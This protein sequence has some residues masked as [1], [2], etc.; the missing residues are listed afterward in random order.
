MDKIY[1]LLET[2]EKH[3]RL[4]EPNTNTVMFG[5]LD[6][7]DLEKT[8]LFPLTHFNLTAIEYNSNTID[9]T[10]SLMALDI[11]N[12]V[13]TEDKSFLGNDN[14]QDVLN[15]QAAVINK[16]VESLRVNKGYLA[17][18][19]FVI[20]NDP[21]AEYLSEKYKNNLAGWGMDIEI[22]TPNDQISTCEIG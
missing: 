21:R 16:L 20:K 6:E 2:I 13:K 19:Q 12:E 11:V 4:N 5:K 3:F 9:F 18:K 22:S 15:T 7:V 1:D 8:T 10:I 14:L 17:D